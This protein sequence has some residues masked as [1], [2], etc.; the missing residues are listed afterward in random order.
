VLDG[1]FIWRYDGSFAAREI[2]YEPL[3]EIRDGLAHT[4]ELLRRNQSARSDHPAH[5]DIR[6]EAGR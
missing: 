3:V 6:A 2:G 5:S 1:S 4:I